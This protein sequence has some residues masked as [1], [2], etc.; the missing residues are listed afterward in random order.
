MRVGVVGSGRGFRV[1]LHG[2]HRKLFVA[3]TFHRPV[4]QIDVGDLQIG[5]ARHPGL[6]SQ[7]GETVVLRCDEHAAGRKILHRMVSAAVA[8]RHLHRLATIS[9]SQQ[10]MAE[11]DA[12]S[13]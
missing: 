7:H 2:E 13:R 6:V 10:L 1:V 9:D 5:G 4:V 8:V 12:E 3:K 11:T